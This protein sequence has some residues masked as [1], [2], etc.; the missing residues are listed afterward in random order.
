MD[1]SCSTKANNRQKAN[2]IYRYKFNN[3][4]KLDRKSLGV[5]QQSRK[6]TTFTT[7][8]LLTSLDSLL[9]KIGGNSNFKDSMIRYSFK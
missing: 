9:D 3:R 1:L 5:K 8:L 2:E 6:T 7:P 4:I